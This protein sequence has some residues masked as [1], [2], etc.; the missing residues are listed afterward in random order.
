MSKGADTDAMARQTHDRLAAID[1]LVNC[2]AMFGTVERKPFW[3]IT[4]EEWDALMAVN[5]RG[6]WLCSEAVFPYMRE[7]GAGRSS[8]SPRAPRSGGRRIPALRD[9]EG[10]ASSG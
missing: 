6:M 10:R 5:L 9:V 8:T 4:E 3:E 1:V 7:Q 2:A